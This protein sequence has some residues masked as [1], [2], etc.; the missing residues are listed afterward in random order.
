MNKMMNNNLS[1]FIMKNTILVVIIGMLT[2]FSH[3][4]IINANP[5]P[6]GE[7]W[8]V[9]KIP[10]YTQEFIERLNEIPELELSHTSEQTILPSEVDNSL[11][12]Y[13]RPIFTQTGNSCA[14]AAGVAYNFTFEI[15]RIRNIDVSNENDTTHYYPTHYT[16]NFLNNGSDNGSSIIE[17]WDIIKEQG[18]PT[19]M[20][21]GGMAGECAR[22]M[23]GYE[24]YDTSFYNR[25][26]SYSKITITDSTELY[27]LKH[28]ISD[29]NE[30]DTSGGLGNFIVDIIG[31][32][33]SQF[34]EGSPE[35]GKTLVTGFGITGRHALTIV[36][37]NDSVR[38]DFNEDSLYTNNMDID[39]NDTIDIRDWELGAVKVANS[40]GIS[41]HTINDSGFVYVPYRLLA[42]KSV[43]G[44]IILNQVYIIHLD[45]SA[46]NQRTDVD[47]EHRP[48]MVLRVK[49][50]HPQRSALNF[51]IGYGQ[52]ADANVPQDSIRNYTFIQ[53]GGPKS[54]QGINDDPIEMEF[55]FSYYF[56]QFFIDPPNPLGKVF[57]QISERVTVDDS[58]TI[59]EYSLV[60]YRWNEQFELIYRDLPHYFLPG[61]GKDTLLM[62]RV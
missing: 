1:R 8:I 5:D 6:N 14:P 10:D 12:K 19:V 24:N 41:Y 62:G 9:G 50:E 17:G 37:Y 47:P 49:M 40:W 3:G 43:N 35:E 16:Y 44:G 26:A 7:V 20:T 60:D 2:H 29:H 46:Q 13:M 42:E 45:T 51:D 11:L 39:E 38:Y 61:S 56:N 58:A 25:L 28:W 55:D 34:P 22:W 27:I 57:M 15:S 54:M 31:A 53:H 59:L 32:N 48:D 30:G 21:W 52:T 18:C 4:Q 23:T 33:Y 36:G